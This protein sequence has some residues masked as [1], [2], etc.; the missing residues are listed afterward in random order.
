VGSAAYRHP[1]GLEAGVRATCQAV[2]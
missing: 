1:G 2:A